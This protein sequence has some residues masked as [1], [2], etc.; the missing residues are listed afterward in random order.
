MNSVERLFIT[1]ANLFP[2]WVLTGAGLALWKP[3]TATWFQPHWIPY[4]L[5]LIM[6]SMG[7]TLSL[8]DF[9]RVLKMPKSILLGVGLQYTIMPGLG[10]ALALGFNLPIDFVVGLVLV[11]CCPGGTASNVVCFIARTHVALS[12]SLTT[13]STLLAVLLTPFLTTWWVES[14]SLEQTGLKVDV[15]TLGL[16]LKTL[17]VVILPV[18]LGIFLNHFFHRG[19]KKVEAY[20]PFVAVLSIVFIVDFILADKKSAILEIGASLI[21]AVLLLHLLGFI[22]GYVLSR[23][24]KFTERDA[25]T[26]SIEVGMQNS[27]LATELARSNFPAYGLATVP[28]AISALTHC[29]LG[30]IAAGLCRWHNASTRNRDH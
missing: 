8:E 22:L 27:G 23:L 14:I 1:L 3:E 12:V 4:F 20:T 26:V 21:V 7:L 18:L 5:G 11:A 16:L 9:S 29:I 15:D 6:L 25:Q 24:L 30:S 2:V 13:C 10:Y 17:K 19:V 28:G